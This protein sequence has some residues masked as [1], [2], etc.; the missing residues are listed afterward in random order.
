MITKTSRFYR[1]P[2][3]V[4]TF[5]KHNRAIVH[6]GQTGKYEF[7]NLGEKSGKPL[8]DRVVP[9]SETKAYKRLKLSIL[10]L[11]CILGSSIAI[12]FIVGYLLIGKV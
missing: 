7:Y 10:V 5:P 12:N 2:W 11:S 1:D 9:V 3:T 8:K 6:N 4:L